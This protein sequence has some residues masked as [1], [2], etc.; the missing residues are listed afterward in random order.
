MKK[1]VKFEFS[2]YGAHTLIS[3]SKRRAETSKNTRGPER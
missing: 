2:I 1:I 3:A